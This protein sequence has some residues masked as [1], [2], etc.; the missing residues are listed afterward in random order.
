MLFFGVCSIEINNF[1]EYKYYP[2]RIFTFFWKVIMN[3]IKDVSTL[4]HCS[5]GRKPPSTLAEKQKGDVLTMKAKETIN[6]I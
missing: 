2:N 4:R 5:V 6:D 3:T 1:F